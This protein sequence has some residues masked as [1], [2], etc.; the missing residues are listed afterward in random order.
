MYV[1][2]TKTFSEF[3]RRHTEFNQDTTKLCVMNGIFDLTTR[4]L[5]TDPPSLL[6]TVQL[7]IKFIPNP[8]TPHIDELRRLYPTQMTNI[9]RFLQTVLRRDFSIEIEFY[10][11]EGTNSGKGTIEAVIE[12]GMKGILSHATLADLDDKH[13]KAILLD[14][15]LNIDTDQDM[16]FMGHKAQADKKKLVGGDRNQTINEKH[17]KQ[18]EYFFGCFF[19]TIANQLPRLPG[20]VDRKATFRRM[21]MEEFMVSTMH[22]DPLFKQHCLEET[23]AW[24][25]Q[26]LLREYAPLLPLTALTLEEHI[27]R[28]ERIYEQYS[29]P[30]R[31]LIQRMFR[32]PPKDPNTTQRIDTQ[33]VLEWVRQ[34]LELQDKN[35]SNDQMLKEWISNEMAHLRIRRTN[36]IKGI[37]YY[38]P[39]EINPEPPLANNKTLWT[40]FIEGGR[41]LPPPSD[42]T[43]SPDDPQTTLPL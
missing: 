4:Q 34:E 38:Y 18:Y 3:T 24:F 26:L 28:N 30:V 29:N 22:P 36:Q 1:R 23:D 9:E 39:I 11:L 42:P 10:L 19:L 21:W 17:V 37:A 32:R 31:I 16:S 27:N 20:V 6:N 2:I 7:P 15:F 40:T 43:D 14:K 41:I 12:K 8:Q 35:A 13:G 33:D 5:M 25:S